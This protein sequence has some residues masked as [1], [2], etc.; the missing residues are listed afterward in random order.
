MD[1]KISGRQRKKKMKSLSPNNIAIPMLK[2]AKFLLRT[3]LVWWLAN[4]QPSES[5]GG[6]SKRTFSSSNSQNA[7]NQQ[8][9]GK[10]KLP[11]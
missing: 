11:L 5:R 6:G 10:L 1:N 3:S 2:E 4:C 8:N 9:L 7:Q